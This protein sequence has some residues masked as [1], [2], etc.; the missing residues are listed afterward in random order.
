MSE[1]RSA[2]IMTTALGLLETI[3]GMIEASTMLSRPIPRTRVSG[4]T[5]ATRPLL[6]T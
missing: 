6:F 3:E 5:T 4:R 2:I 1:A